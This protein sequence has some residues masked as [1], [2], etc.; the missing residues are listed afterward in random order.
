MQSSVDVAVVGAGAAGLIAARRLAEAGL[1]VAVLEARGR[2]GGRILT[3]EGPELPLPAE[4]GA[5]FIHGTAAVSFALLREA[6]AV[7]IDTVGGALTYVDGALR[8][9]D[10][11]FED[12][13]RALGRARETL[14]EDVS[15]AEFVRTLDERERVAILQMVQGFDAADPA[16]AGTL[17][18]AEEW[19]GGDAGQTARQFRPLG[20]YGPLVRTLRQTL[21]P[22]R[23]ELRLQTTVTA[24]RYGADGCIVEAAGP[25]GE[26]EPLRARA[27]LVTVPVG[28]LQAGTIGFDPPLDAAKTRALAEILM[29]PVVKLVLCFRTAFWERIA[30]G[31]YIDVAFFHRPEAHFPTIWTQLP[32]RAPLLVAWAGGPR[33][34]LLRDRDDAALTAAVLDDLDVLFGPEGDPRGELESVYVH[35][36]QRDPHALGAYSYLVTGAGASRE[37][38]AAPVGTR[39]F[40]AGEATASIGEAGTVAGALQSGERA[41]REIVAA[42][43]VERSR[44][45]PG[46]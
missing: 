38:L 35:D 31:R 13:A 29:G 23:V 3:V 39:L 43:G 36:W 10:D 4:L 41:A 8:E 17:A 40:F 37:A 34:D 28:I 5:E 32:L 7:A 44:P 21:D 6:N 14:R 30:G 15:I 19:S 33:A 24:I 46:E 45:Q 42:L 18:L 26:P 16:R 25:G 11:P 9:R 12:A 22:D 2:I 20:G 1:R 27:V